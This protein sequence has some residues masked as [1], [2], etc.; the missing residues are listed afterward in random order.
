MLH[1]FTPLQWCTVVY[2]Q[3][4]DVGRLDQALILFGLALYPLS[5]L[6]IQSS[7]YCIYI[8]IYIY[9]HIFGYILYLLVS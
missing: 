2:E 3:F 1:C 8:Y 9:T 7:W 6:Y 4:L 5:I